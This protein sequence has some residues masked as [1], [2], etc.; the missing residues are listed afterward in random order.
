MADERGGRGDHLF[1]REQP[2]DEQTAAAPFSRSSSSVAAARPLRPVRSTLVAPI[3]PD[4]IV[5]RSPAPPSRVRITPNGSSPA[6]SRAPAPRSVPSR[7]FLSASVPLRAWPHHSGIGP[8][9]PR[10]ADLRRTARRLCTRSMDM[11]PILFF[12]SGVGGCRWS[13]RLKDCCVRADRLCG[14]FGWVSLWYE[15]EA[16]IAAR[17]RR[18]SGGWSNAIARGWW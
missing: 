4:P 10:G 11:R 5:R 8:A 2:A 1:A 14:R 9:W 7:G 16:E 18:C 12:D 6:D 15:S 3:L 17:C 13:H